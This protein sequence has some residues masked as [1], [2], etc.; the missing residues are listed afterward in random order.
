MNLLYYNNLNI[1][2]YLNILSKNI[3]ELLNQKKKLQNINKNCYRKISVLKRKLME[4]ECSKNK[5]QCCN[6]IENN[7]SL[8]TLYKIIHYDITPISWSNEKINEILLSIKS[9]NDII[10]LD[11]YWLELKHNVT[12]QRLY[13]LIPALK[14]LND[15]IGLTKIKIDI[16][17][18][19]IYYC[20]NLFNDE[21]LHTVIMGPPGVGKTEFAKIYADI[22]VRLNILKSNKFIS[23]KRDDLVGEYLGQTSVKTRKLLESSLD[24]VIFL[25]EAYSL[26]NEEKRDSFSKEAIDMINLF[27]SEK[28]GSLMF[29]IAGYEEDIAKCF[30]AFNKGLKRR[31]HT[32][33][34]IDGYKPLELKEIFIKKINQLYYN[35][36][37]S[38]DDLNNFF[39]SNN[40]FTN[41]GGDIEKLINEIKQ[42]QALRTFNKNIDN[43]D[44]IIDDIKQAYN[45]LFYKETKTDQY[46]FLYT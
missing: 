32:Y 8:D 6:K 34:T 23:I 10:K 45:N 9:I 35:L 26:G 29:I 42:I 3:I 37:I 27:L 12:L 20:K 22:F 15:M 40:G 2:I 21:Y 5:K 36:S 24:G 4:Y 30:F 11:N 13:Y 31:F 39:I 33:Y 43:K 41:Y 1:I 28:K 38:D 46:M 16:F 18:K 44:I 25:D 7:I 14:K 19:I 17:K